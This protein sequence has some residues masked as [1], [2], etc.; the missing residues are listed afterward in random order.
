MVLAL[1]A[2]N[3]LHDWCSHVH[4]HASDKIPQFHQFNHAYVHRAKESMP[5]I[6]A[7]WL[8]HSCKV[9]LNDKADPCAHKVNA[10]N[11][12]ALSEDHSSPGT[13]P[14]AIV[15]EQSYVLHVHQS[16]NAEDVIWCIRCMLHVCQ[17]L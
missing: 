11:L 4:I 1:N 3:G 12:A 6:P 10:S 16:P 9:H 14:H 13:E 15:G 17:F 5:G 8:C 7:S 2:G